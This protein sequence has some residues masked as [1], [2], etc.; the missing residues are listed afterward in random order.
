VNFKI[1]NWDNWRFPKLPI[2][3]FILTAFGKVTI[4]YI[5]D[6]FCNIS[7]PSQKVSTKMVKA[8]FNST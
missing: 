4:G 1:K 2:T 6:G 7:L 5:C 8:G 3:I